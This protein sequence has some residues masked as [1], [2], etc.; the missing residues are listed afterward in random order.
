MP[1]DE[2]GLV[3]RLRAKINLLEAKPLLSEAAAAIERLLAERD[4]A[5]ESATVA[6]RVAVATGTKFIAAEAQRD[7]LKGMVEQ[8]FRDGMI[9]GNNVTVTDPDEAWRTSRARQA[10]ED[11]QP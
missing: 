4:E 8:A 6:Q 3:E 2:L 9:Y 7:K 10:L 5:R 11:S 1:I